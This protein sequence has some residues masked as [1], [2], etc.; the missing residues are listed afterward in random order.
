MLFVLFQLDFL[1]QLIQI[2]V[3]P[4]PHIA[5]TPGVRE[6]FGVFALFA[7]DHR[8][9][10]LYP[11]SLRQVQKLVDDLVHGLLADFPSA[12]GTV[13]RTRP[14]PEQAE[15]VI[16]FRDGSDGG[17]GVFAG[18][19]L[20]N[21]DSGGEAVNGVHVRL[22][23]LPQKH[24]GVG[25][26]G[27]DIAPLSLGIDGVKGQRRF[28]GPG[29]AR[30]HHQ[31]VPWNR[32]VDIFQIVGARAP[33]NNPVLHK[34]Y[35]SPIRAGPLPMIVHRRSVLRFSGYCKSLFRA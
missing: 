34:L 1:I 25:G 10:Y 33:D 29:K 31:F 19:L 6:N 21:G 18:G 8:G 15:I 27:L 7:P 23:H 26:E 22:V 28:A 24:P 17:T 14:R 3:R 11:R 35:N 9:H 20:V 5:G 13:G 12:A 30:H 32:H 16:D 4:Y 2:P